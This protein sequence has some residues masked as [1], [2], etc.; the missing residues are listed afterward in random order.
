[1]LIW[2]LLVVVPAMGA[3]ALPKPWLPWS[4]ALVA[5][6]AGAL[7][8][9]YDGSPH[10]DPWPILITPPAVIFIVAVGIRLCQDVF[11]RARRRRAELQ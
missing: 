3:Y 1:M 5:L 10:N 7:W 6:V 9:T 11:S 2:A 4:I 8:L